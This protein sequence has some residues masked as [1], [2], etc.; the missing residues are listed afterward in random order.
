MN[1]IVFFIF[2]WAVAMTI[3]Y[4]T[5]TLE[6]NFIG[7]M[8]SGLFLALMIEILLIFVVMLFFLVTKDG[9]EITENMPIYHISENGKMTEYYT[10]I[11][12]NKWFIINYGDEQLID[13]S[14]DNI[15]NEYEGKP[16]IEITTMI[17]NENK[18][19]HNILPSF[20]KFE[21]RTL[22]VDK[23]K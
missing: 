12:D 15:V 1:E 17:P 10:K 9:V 20:Q 11:T 6:D 22:Y 16:H 19:P 21:Y 3:L 5:N 18:F 4:G 13:N 14:I 2:L 7:S 23:I 8:F